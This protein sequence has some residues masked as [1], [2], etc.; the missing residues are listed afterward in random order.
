MQR[1]S[2]ISI[3]IAY[4]LAIAVSAC[5]RQSNV[6]NDSPVAPTGASSAAVA[7]VILSPGAVMAGG[8]I[9][10]TVLL[11]AP[12]TSSLDVS[13]SASDDAASVDPV[14]TIPAGSSSR[15]FTITTRAVPGDRQVVI[16]ASAS[17]RSARGT[18]ELWAEAPVFF[19]Y[20]SEG[21]DFVGG[22]RFGHFSQERA[23]FT[24][25]C[26]R[27]EVNVRLSVPGV[28]SWQAQFSGPF[29]VPL[30]TGTYEGATRAGF[31]SS[32]PGLSISG[33]G[34][35][36]NTISGRFV[37]HDIDL[38]NNRVNRFHASYVQRCDGQPG[39]L[40]GEVMVVN[41]PPSSFVVNCQR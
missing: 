30:R 33:Q 14:L 7:S 13:L 9:Q 32:S 16:S 34:R 11:T 20:F 29:G 5:N 23:T 6:F 18:F 36:C 1:P 22:A 31:N 10:G 2:V 24:A 28:E 37:I 41:M 12:A 27:N 21:G 38:Q 4:A 3:V 17:G 39:L 35:G 40:S 15:E 25:V 8:S 26:D 19:T